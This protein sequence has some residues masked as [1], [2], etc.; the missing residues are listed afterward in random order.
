M[1]MKS[2]VHSPAKARVNGVVP[3]IDAWYDAFDIKPGDKMYI[4]ADKRVHIW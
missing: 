2:D 3:M 1:Q 4:P